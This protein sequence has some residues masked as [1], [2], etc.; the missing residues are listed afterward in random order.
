M[1]IGSRQ[2]RNYLYA[3]CASSWPRGCKPRVH[4]KTQNKAQRLAACGHVRKQPIIALYFE[5]ETVPKVYSLKA[6]FCDVLCAFPG[7]SVNLQVRGVNGGVGGGACCLTVLLNFVCVSLSK[8]SPSHCHGL[9]FD[10]R[11]WQFSVIL[12]FFEWFSVLV[13]GFMSQ[14]TAMVMLRWS[15]SLTTLFPGLA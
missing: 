2:I 11:L 5:F 7:F 15:V 10:L 9:V 6:W 13:C 1:L 4:S 8:I 14:S 3:F 12:A